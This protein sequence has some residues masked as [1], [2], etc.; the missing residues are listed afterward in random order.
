MNEPEIMKQWERGAK[1]WSISILS[2][3]CWELFKCNSVG[4]HFPHWKFIFLPYFAD[5]GKFNR[6]LFHSLIS[7][8]YQPEW[9]VSTLLLLRTNICRRLSKYMGSSIHLLLDYQQTTSLFLSL[10]YCSTEKRKKQGWMV[11]TLSN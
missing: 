5:F 2:A 6:K 8:L 1:T 7:W 11:L 10:L 9:G 4:P 3:E